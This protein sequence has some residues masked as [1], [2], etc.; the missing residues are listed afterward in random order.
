M[1]TYL[2]VFLSLIFVA[3]A[4]GISLSEK[5]R[6]EKDIIEATVRTFVQLIIVGYVLKF[7]FA[8]N[9]LYWTGGMITVMTIVGAYT[10]AGRAKGIPKPFPITAAAMVSSVLTALIILLCLKIVSTEPMYL[11][12]IAGMVIGNTMNTTTIVMIRTREGIFDHRESIEASLALGKSPKVSC[13]NVIKSA[14]RLSLIPKLDIVKVGGI[15]H[16]PGAMTG[17]ILAGASP[18]QAVKFQLIIMYLIIGAPAVAAVIS[19]RMAYRRFFNENE[20]LIIP[21]HSPKAIKRQRA[22]HSSKVKIK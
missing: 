15:I 12:P 10:S 9:K 5:L 17:M 13:S 14:V 1:I 7:I 6:L 11:I 22:E 20:Q 2:D 4:F 19:S 3:I 16:M 8:E 18:M 21:Q